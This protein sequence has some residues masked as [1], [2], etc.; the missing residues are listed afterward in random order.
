MGLVCAAAGF[1]AGADSAGTILVITSSQVPAYA[2]ALEGINR[3]FGEAPGRITVLDLE[4]HSGALAQEIAQLKP[5]LV[6][7][8]GSDALEALASHRVTAPI[9]SSMVLSGH[10]RSPADLNIVATISLH[11]P[12]MGL[13][14]ELKRVFP[15][16]TRL[17]VLR[18]PS[19]GGTGAA[20][21]QLRAKEHGFSI[22]I[23]D[24]S[25]P[26]QLLKAFLSLKGEVDFVWCR[27]DNSLFNSSTVK[28]LVLA[29][30][31][32]GL[33]IIGFSESFVR[34]GA[35]FGMYAD[36]E[37]IGRQAAEAARK[38]LAGETPARGERPR[39]FKLAVNERVIRILGLRYTR[40]ESP[41]ADFLVLR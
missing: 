6:I 11:V 22:R 24:C 12:T 21:L 18:N 20:A 39:K 33:P 40:P 35:A 7:A 23:A 2:Q 28:P 32:H 10:A 14:A 8:L 29:S 38:C 4:R 36:F 37:D 13:L 34:A 41:G 25:G 15:G 1:S 27:P 26:E 19:S 9:V 31:Q 3:T 17:G 16:K 30:L 5:R